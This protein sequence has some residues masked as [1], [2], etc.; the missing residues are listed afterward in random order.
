M[1]EA[2]GPASW[3]ELR[4]ILR[5]P[6]RL[7]NLSRFQR[8]VFVGFH[9]HKKARKVQPVGE[10]TSPKTERHRWRFQ[11]FHLLG[12]A[13][14][15]QVGIVQLG[16]QATFGLLE[17]NERLLTKL[18][19]STECCCNLLLSSD[20]WYIIYLIISVHVTSAYTLHMYRS[21]KFTPSLASG[22]KNGA[23]HHLGYQR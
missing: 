1:F 18:A 8:S 17:V 6:G 15:Q 21:A 22:L 4:L 16:Q 7:F 9:I 12:T 23:R 19:K 5:P 2:P 11:S 20:F 3:A 14:F 13:Q 10:M